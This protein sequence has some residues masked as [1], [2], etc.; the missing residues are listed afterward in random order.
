MLRGETPLDRPRAGEEG[1]RVPTTSSSSIIPNTANCYPHQTSGGNSKTVSAPY[2]IPFTRPH[3]KTSLE[4]TD[5]IDISLLAATAGIFPY[6]AKH[7]QVKAAWEEVAKSVNVECNLPSDGPKVTERNARDRVKLLLDKR[8]KQE[9]AGRKVSSY[10]PVQARKEHLLEE[11]SSMLEYLEETTSENKA[12]KER[13]EREDDFLSKETPN[14]LSNDIQDY[15]PD[16]MEADPARR[17]VKKRRRSRST[18]PNQSFD[19]ATYLARQSEL[20][21]Q[22]LAL[23]KEEFELRKK[24]MEIAEKRMLMDKEREERQ[25]KKDEKMLELITTVIKIILK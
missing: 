22:Q 24:Q 18:P 13:E 15:D 16:D 10:S 8:R 12:E 21:A 14:Y 17:V 7:G 19:F 1:A 4:F 3:V 11:L 9:A 6:D 5:L 2:E 20:E 25:A 23:R